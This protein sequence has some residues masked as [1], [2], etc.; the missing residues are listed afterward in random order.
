[1]NSRQQLSRKYA[2]A[3]LGI[4]ASAITIETVKN[5]Q[6]AIID[7]K[8]QKALSFYLQLTVIDSD[9]KKKFLMEYIQ[10]AS[11]P[12]SL[13]KLVELLIDHK[14]AFLFTCVLE[15]LAEI[16]QQENSIETFVFYSAAPL[17]EVLAE[18]LRQFLAAKTERAIIYEKRVEKELIA[19]IRLQS[20]TKLWEHSLAQQLR[21]MQNALMQ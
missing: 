16:Y 20:S 3:W 1:M 6:A 21:I 8:K 2:Q 17:D 7:L 5:L 10:A 18:K 4:Y 19:G 15:Q 11:L 13:G 9:I 12:E 14:R